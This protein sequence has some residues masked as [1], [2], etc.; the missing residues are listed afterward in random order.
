MIVYNYPISKLGIC[1][2]VEI[3]SPNVRLTKAKIMI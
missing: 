2:L 1:H 3:V